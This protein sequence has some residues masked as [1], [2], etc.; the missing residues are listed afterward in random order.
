MFILRRL[1][2]VS[3]LTVTVVSAT[4]AAGSW[5]RPKLYGRG[6][7]IG[8]SD[9]VPG[10]AKKAVA[11]EPASP[12][13]LFLKTIQDARRH[14]AAAAAARSVSIFAMYPIDTIKVTT[15]YGRGTLSVVSSRL[16]RC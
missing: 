10:G 7:A 16:T 3:L 1:V 6:V 11:A 15:G 12:L 9:V 14:L 2:F 5:A 8:S 13:R 4:V